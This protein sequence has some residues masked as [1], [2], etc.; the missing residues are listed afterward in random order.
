M[1]GS[2]S[3]N[4]SRTTHSGNGVKA[5]GTHGDHLDGSV[6]LHRGNRVTGIDRTL[7]GVRRLH[8]NDLGDLVNVQ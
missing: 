2:D 4:R 8:R 5:G 3:F 1:R 7:E 6:R